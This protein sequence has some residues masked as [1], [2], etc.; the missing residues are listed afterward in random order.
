M[1]LCICYAIYSKFFPPEIGE[2]VA[3][4]DDTEVGDIQN[5]EFLLNEE[6]GK[7]EE[8]KD[9]PKLGIEPSENEIAEKNSTEKEE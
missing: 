2:P 5:E 4:S 9:L 7:E 3:L 8:P 1:V 6:I